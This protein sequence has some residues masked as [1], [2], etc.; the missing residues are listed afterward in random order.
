MHASSFTARDFASPTSA[1]SPHR[2]ATLKISTTPPVVCLLR[3]SA[4]PRRRSRAG[5]LRSQGRVRNVTARASIWLVISQR[6]TFPPLSTTLRR[7]PVPDLWQVMQP[8]PIG[9]QGLS[10][11]AIGVGTRQRGFSVEA[12]PLAYPRVFGTETA[13]ETVELI[14]C[15]SQ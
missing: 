3:P 6:P 14:P 2:M 8:Y 9:C 7:R 10:R 13:R 5:A 11:I 4:S 15:S 1:H 12:C